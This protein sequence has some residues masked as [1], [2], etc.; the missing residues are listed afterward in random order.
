MCQILTL[1]SLYKADIFS[2][3]EENNQPAKSIQIWKRADLPQ[4]GC[5]RLEAS[6]TLQGERLEA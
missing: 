3:S 6:L 2:V 5:L 4:P 1:S